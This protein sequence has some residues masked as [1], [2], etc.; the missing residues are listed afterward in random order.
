MY[1]HADLHQ[2]IAASR[3]PTGI[4]DLSFKTIFSIALPIYGS[5]RNVH[6]S[7]MGNKSALVH[8][9]L[10]QHE[11]YLQK[12]STGLVNAAHI[13]RHGLATWRMIPICRRAWSTLRHHFRGKNTSIS[14]CHGSRFDPCPLN[15]RC[16]SHVQAARAGRAARHT[17]TTLLPQACLTPTK[18]SIGP[19]PW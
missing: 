11:A 18:A 12:G 4:P 14:S 2:S 19:P 7:F 15:T 9:H 1:G 13:S 5:C 8:Q 16:G 17:A 6:L 3:C 10:L